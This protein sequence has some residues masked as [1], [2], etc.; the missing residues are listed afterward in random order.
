MFAKEETLV[1][2]EVSYHERRALD[3]LIFFSDGVFAIAITLLVL[4]VAV[5]VIQ[6]GSV[7]TELP[8]ALLATAPKLFS[9]V[10]SFLV[11]GAYGW[12]ISA[13]FTISNAT[14]VLSRG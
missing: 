3:R 1:Q 14:I 4:N 9:Y 5:P 13:R 7:A 6:T 10:L 8:S 11:I 2:S 12:R